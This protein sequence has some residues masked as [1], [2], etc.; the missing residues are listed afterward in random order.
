MIVIASPDACTGCL[1]CEMVCS[2]HHIGKYSISQSS[3]K[4]NKSILNR[5]KGPKIT[6]FYEKD[7]WSPVC[8]MCNLEDSPLCMRFCPE[9]VFKLE[10]GME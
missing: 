10:K 6:I 9:N 1:I 5:E 4:V 2:F 8:D 7:K 3:I